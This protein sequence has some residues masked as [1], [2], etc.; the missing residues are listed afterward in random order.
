MYIEPTLPTTAT[1][2]QL[3]FNFKTELR[4]QK[5]KHINEQKRRTVISMEI[6]DAQR[7][8]FLVYMHYASTDHT[9]YWN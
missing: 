9:R 3:K 2:R 5:K 6:W 8:H 1:K 7:F 4:H